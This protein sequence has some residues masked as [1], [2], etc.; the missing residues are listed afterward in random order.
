MDEEEYISFSITIS[1]LSFACLVVI[2]LWHIFQVGDGLRVREPYFRG[3]ER[4]EVTRYLP[5]LSLYP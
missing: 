1:S 3:K 2:A 5:L 4:E